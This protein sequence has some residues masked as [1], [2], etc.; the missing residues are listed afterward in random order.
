MF[1]GQSVQNETSICRRDATGESL[2]SVL[3]LPALTQIV[4]G[5]ELEV[6]VSS[7][8]TFFFF[9]ETFLK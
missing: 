2:V 9:E 1:L 4:F 8:E 3:C 6:H 7:E 5:T